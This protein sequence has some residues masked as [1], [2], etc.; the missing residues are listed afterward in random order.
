MAK[1]LIADKIAQQ[2]IDLLSREHEVEVKT[3]LSEDDL[4]AAIADAKALIVR[5]QT[6]VTA[7]VLAAAAQLE[8]VARAG[9]GVDNVDVSAATE[10]GVVVV[11]AP[12]ANTISTAEHAFGLMLAAARN[13]P[14]GHA[15]L[16]GGAW[17]R[18]RLQ[19]VE[20]AGK[21]LGVV[22]LGR[23]GSEF[24]KRARAFEM[25]VVAFDPY[26]TSERAA[27]LGVE[28]MELDELLAEADFVTLHTALTEGN[29][30]M[31][32]A[33]RLANMKKTAIL[34]NAARGA[35]V[36]E[37][38]LYD[39]VNNGVIGGAAIDVF[40]EEPAVGNILTTHPKIV[41]TPHLAAST[42]EAQDRAAIDV[43]EQVLEVLGGGAPR[44]PVNVPT[45][46]PETMA[47]I[48]PYLSAAH[49]AGSIA[50]QIKVGNLQSVR[51]E[52]RGAIGNQKDLTPLKASA[53]AGLLTA[54]LDERVS[55]VNALAEAE[56]RGMRLDETTG[57]ALAPYTSV[58]TVVLTTDQGQETVSATIAAGGPSIVGIDEYPVELEQ[59]GATDH[60]L[61][62]ENIDRPGSIG[63]VGTLLGGLDVNVSSMSVAPGTDGESALM[64]L[65]VSRQL[66]EDEAGQVA[67]LDGIHRVR[68]ARVR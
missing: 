42:N 39:A 27:T 55:A 17:E 25:R 53:A 51:L 28:M 38:A 33:E 49:L 63:R 20:V 12:H 31:I 60:V 46:D 35:L 11:N 45:V 1:I 40:S 14:Q 4:C 68:Q 43:A 32:N 24:A 10:H 37:Q 30:G 5:S 8:I 58:V 2:G 6:Q 48:G 62:I 19:G 56:A 13:T 23:I 44:F 18:S 22:G 67:A 52:Y 34:V 64:L 7:K 61:L 41:V 65:G 21:T 3:G 54:V 26:V 66:T 50:M 29:R 59:D 57:D 47:I 36:D 9:V 15:S 16:Q